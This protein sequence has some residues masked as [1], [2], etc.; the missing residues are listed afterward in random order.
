MCGTCGRPAPPTAQNKRRQKPRRGAAALTHACPPPSP[1]PPPPP[2]PSLSYHIAASRCATTRAA[3]HLTLAG[4]FSAGADAGAI[5]RDGTDASPLLGRLLEELHDLFAAE[6]LSVLDPTDLALL[7]RACWKCG[8]AVV[9]SGFE[10]AG[11]SAEE[12][13]R[14]TDFVRSVE[15]LAWGKDNGCPWNERTCAPPLREGT[16][17]RCGGRGSTIAGGTQGRVC[18][19]LGAA[20][21]RCW[22]GRGSTTAR[23]A[24]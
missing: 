24:L 20:T 1:P 13:L 14:L 18:P 8:E 11:E 12:P 5:V 19:L 21:W 16:W 23:G 3:S 22:C 10:I 9:P 7:A 2:P 6:V 15:V 17:R 4:I